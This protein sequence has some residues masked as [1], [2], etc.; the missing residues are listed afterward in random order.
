M[1]PKA[2]TLSP[3]SVVGGSPVDGMVTLECPAGPGEI[4]V[5]LSSS[6][7]L[8]A[9]PDTL[10]ITVPPGMTTGLFTVTTAPVGKITK[11]S[12][13]ATANGKTKSKT[14]SVTPAPPLLTA[15]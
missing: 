7:P 2:V 15:P 4:V 6:K 3:T 10:G 8:V 12:I 14:L 13:S 1:G 9:V 5:T 11:P